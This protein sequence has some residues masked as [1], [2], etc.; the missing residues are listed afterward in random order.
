LFLN[1]ALH[2]ARTEASSAAR[3]VVHAAGEH[4]KAGPQGRALCHSSG[5]RAFRVV[6]WNGITLLFPC[7]TGAGVAAPLLVRAA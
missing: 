1:G 5:S 3:M 7:G 4:N 6:L 2:V